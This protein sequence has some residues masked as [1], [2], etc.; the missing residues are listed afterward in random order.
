MQLFQRENDLRDVYPDLVLVE[1]LPL[2]QVCEEFAAGHVVCGQSLVLEIRDQNNQSVGVSLPC[3]SHSGPKLRKG[4]QF[5][6]LIDFDRWTPFR[7]PSVQ[8]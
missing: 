7:P 8:R 6:V 1:V 3:F 4:K 2:V 5:R